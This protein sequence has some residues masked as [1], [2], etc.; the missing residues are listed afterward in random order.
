[1]KSDDNLSTAL[2]ITV[3]VDNL[4][5]V[6]LSF[7][8]IVYEDDATLL[9][10]DTDFINLVN[11]WNT[12]LKLFYDRAL[13]SR[14]SINVNKTGCIIFGNRSVDFGAPVFVLSNVQIEAESRSRFLGIILEYKVKFNHHITFIGDNVSKSDGILL[15][16]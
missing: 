16:L 6:F 1:M 3:N 13:A 11:V 5:S 8:K 9:S 10:S 4:F 7:L 15:K 2:Q 14:L 12:E